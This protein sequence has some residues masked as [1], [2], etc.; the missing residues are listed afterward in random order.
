MMK[1]FQPALGRIVRA[2]IARVRAVTRPEPVS[3]KNTKKAGALRGRIWV[4][5]RGR[6]R[7][8]LSDAPSTA[9]PVTLDIWLD[10]EKV[11]QTIAV[12]A[13]SGFEHRLPID[14]RFK[15]AKLVSVS[16][17]ERP[18]ARISREI[19][20]DPKLLLRKVP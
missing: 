1:F 14:A 16:L 2:V 9:E 8:R 5:A 19:S 11:G 13:S 4:S 3:A 20:A 6:I 12:D 18:D 7:G 10:D 17:A 15:S